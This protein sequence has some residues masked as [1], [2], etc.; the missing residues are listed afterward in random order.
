MAWRHKT[1]EATVPS[2]P[3]FQNSAIGNLPT[4]K[5][6]PWVSVLPA[7]RGLW[8]MIVTFRERG[9]HEIADNLEAAAEKQAE[10][11]LKTQQLMMNKHKP[12][13]I[14][15]PPNQSPTHKQT[16]SRTPSL[17]LS[18]TEVISSKRSSRRTSMRNSQCSPPSQYTM[19]T[20]SESE[21]E[22]EGEVEDGDHER[23]KSRKPSGILSKVK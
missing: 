6:P 13:Q 2:S 7:A 19:A 8:N 5:E 18:G 1:Y 11:H 9:S 4:N 20:T 3:N 10:A 17:P 12:P 21:W 23:S 15:T 14:Q 22:S 16:K